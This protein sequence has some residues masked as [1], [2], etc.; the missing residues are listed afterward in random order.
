MFLVEPASPP[1]TIEIVG[2]AK[3]VDGDTLQ[4]GTASIRLFAIDAPETR[5]SCS[6]NQRPVACGA[7]ASDYLRRK[8]HGVVVRCV[9][10]ETDRYGRMVAT[11]TTGGRDIGA[12]M[13]T[14]GW[15]TAFRSY[16]T[17]Y[18]PQEDLAKAAHRG[19]WATTFEAPGDYRARQ[20]AASVAAAPL[21]PNPQCPIKGNI[22]DKGEQIF[23][24]PGSR[25]YPDV[26]I[27]L[28]AGERWFC[29]AQQAVAAGW[30]APK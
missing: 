11:C 15:A 19:L 21:A 23:H 20:R 29:S 28:A 1:A 5:Q 16:S 14:A 9:S 3:V 22:N 13:V 4:I 8:T 27:N 6:S 12:D 7:Q 18:V 24:L 26:K 25:P 2:Y 10:R 30:R 17:L